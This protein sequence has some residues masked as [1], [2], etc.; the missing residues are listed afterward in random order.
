MRAH[1]PG[2]GRPPPRLEG[3]AGSRDAPRQRVV[4][5]Q[6]ER[7]RAARAAT[8]AM[9]RLVARARPTP[10]GAACPRTPPRRA[11]CPTPAHHE[12]ARRAGTAPRSR[13]RRRAATAR[14]GRRPTLPRRPRTR[15]RPPRASI[16][17]VWNSPSVPDAHRARAAA[18]ATPSRTRCGASARTYLLRV[19]DLLGASRR[20][21]A[22]GEV[23]ERPSGRP[24]A[25]AAPRRTPARRCRGT[26][27]APAGTPA[28][29]RCRRTRP[30][31]RRRASPRP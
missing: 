9:P 18:A 20:A 1:I 30:P 27:A 16:S 25:R 5:R 4:G 14:S 11:A 29:T 13:P 17:R 24:R 6:H 12:H 15:R 7:D 10:T 31:A 26:R 23:D 8:I 22:L 28:A 21:R 3:S 2:I 19:H